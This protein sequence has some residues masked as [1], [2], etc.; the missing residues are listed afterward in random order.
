VPDGDGPIDF[1]CGVGPVRLN[2]DG[3]GEV[4]WGQ[5]LDPAR[6]VLLSV[7]LPE[8]GFCWSDVVLNDGQPVGT[9]RY[10]GRELP[11]FNALAL[12]QRSPFGTYIARV[13]MPPDEAL[14]VQLAEI[15]EGRD[16]AIEDWSSSIRPMCRACS[17]GRPHEG[18]DEELRGLR[19]GTR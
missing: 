4:V 8:S 17:E 19:G 18:H 14:I 7:P 11:V 2:P 9:R 3:N 16:G 12:L 10:R 1:P 15:A 6:M 5:R 13:E